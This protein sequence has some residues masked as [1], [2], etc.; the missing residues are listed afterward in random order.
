MVIG[1]KTMTMAREVHMIPLWMIPKILIDYAQKLPGHWSKLNTHIYLNCMPTEA[2]KTFLATISS[3]GEKRRCA[4]RNLLPWD[5][6]GQWPWTWRC[7]RL[8]RS[9][10]LLRHSCLQLASPRAPARAA[11][12]RPSTP[13]DG[14]TSA[15]FLHTKFTGTVNNFKNLMLSLH[16][17]VLRN[18]AWGL[19]PL[20]CCS[21]SMNCRRNWFWRRGSRKANGTE[22]APKM[23]WN[24]FIL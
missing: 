9:Q 17:H 8:P 24:Q 22:N 4:G 19:H 15:C 20:Y 11:P 5:P 6:N 7:G 1:S 18:L 16:G 12:E 21:H 3:L 2:G 14:R 23:V 13:R 10:R